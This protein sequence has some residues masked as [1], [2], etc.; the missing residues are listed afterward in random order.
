MRRCENDVVDPRLLDP[1]V[2]VA[3]RDAVDEVHVSGRVALESH[4]L[5]LAAERTRREGRGV[6]ME[7][8]RETVAR[9][10]AGEVEGA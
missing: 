1:F 4:L 6:V 7:E 5:G 3:A 9:E 10:A 2:E 8:W